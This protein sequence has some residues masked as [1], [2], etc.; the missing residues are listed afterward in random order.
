MGFWIQVDLYFGQLDEMGFYSPRNEMEALNAILSLIKSSFCSQ[1]H[2]QTHAQQD[3]RNAIVNR[4][5]EF[6]AKNTVKS[7]IDINYECD[8]EKCLVQ[9]AENRGVKT[10]LQIACKFEIRI[11]ISVFPF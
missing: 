5:H 8:K 11:A 1:V 4:I 10:R 9:W 6:G 2:I 7:K 3:L